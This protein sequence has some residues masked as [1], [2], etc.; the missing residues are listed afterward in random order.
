MGTFLTFW[1]MISTDRRQSMHYRLAHRSSLG[2]NFRA[3]N[4]YDD[5]PSHRYQT[6]SL[7]VG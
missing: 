3:E 2:Y 1:A 4:F 5:G 7:S 6:R